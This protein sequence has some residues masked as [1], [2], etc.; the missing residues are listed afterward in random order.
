MKSVKKIG[1]VKIWTLRGIAVGRVEDWKVG[2]GEGGDL[3]FTMW[4]PD[5]QLDKGGRRENCEA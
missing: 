1:G 4:R 5:P 3:S 2:C